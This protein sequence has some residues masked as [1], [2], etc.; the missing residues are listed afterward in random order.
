MIKHDKARDLRPV[1]LD[2][3]ESFYW[4]ASIPLNLPEVHSVIDFG[5]GRNLNKAILEHFD[6]DCFTV[7]VS[8]VYQPDLISPIVQGL[9][10]PQADLVSCFQCLEHNSYLDMLQ[11]IQTLMSYSKKYLYISLPYNGAYFSLKGS[12]RIPKVAKRFSFVFRLCGFGGRHIDEGKLDLK[13]DQYRHHRWELGRPK[14]KVADFIKNVDELGFKHTLTQH[15]TSY[16][17]HL[18]ILFEK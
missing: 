1:R 14:H 13:T 17:N 12:L 18:F 9:E 5:S 7:D 10:I 4:Q 16:P 2:M 6:I 11:H 15:N 8:P 3:W